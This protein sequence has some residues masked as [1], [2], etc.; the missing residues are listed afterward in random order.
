MLRPSKGKVLTITEGTE[1]PMACDAPTNGLGALETS[2]L[3]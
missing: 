3:F 2:I 1:K